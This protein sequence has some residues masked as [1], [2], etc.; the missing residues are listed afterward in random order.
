[1]RRSTAAKEAQRHKRKQIVSKIKNEGRRGPTRL[2]R[3]GK[4][5][6]KTAGRFKRKQTKSKM[7]SER[8][9]GPT[10][11]RRKRRL[12][13]TRATTDGKGKMR[14]ERRRGPTRLRRKGRIDGKG[15]TK[16]KRKRARRSAKFSSTGCRE[17]SATRGR[18]THLAREV[19]PCPLLSLS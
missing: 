4:L 14:S 12:E 7:E 3:K 15:K 18:D 19:E 1:M 8:S 13:R 17:V 11:L 5:D 6:R 9:K 10:R 2:R 16:S